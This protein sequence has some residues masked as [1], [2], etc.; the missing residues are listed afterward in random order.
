MRRLVDLLN[1]A[2]LRCERNESTYW[3]YIELLCANTFNGYAQN[4]QEA[5]FKTVML[6]IRLPALRG[7]VFSMVS[8]RDSP[9]VNACMKQ[10][11]VTG[12]LSNRG[13]QIAASCLI[14]ELEGDWRYGAAW[15]ESQLIDYDVAANWGTGNIWPVSELT[16]GEVVTSTWQSRQKFM[17]QMAATGRAGYTKDDHLDHASP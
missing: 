14:N 8:R 6:R 1:E 4:R 13:R 5:L 17:M 10:L 9:L 12:Y 11:S 3:L 2:E 7:R 16:L 15:F